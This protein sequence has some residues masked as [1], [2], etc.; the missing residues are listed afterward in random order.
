MSIRRP[1]QLFVYVSKD[2]PISRLTLLQLDAILGPNICEA[3]QRTSVSGVTSGSPASGQAN[4]ST[5]MATAL[6][7]GLPSTSRRRCLKE[8]GYGTATSTRLGGQF[9]KS[10]DED[11]KRAIEVVGKD[12]YAILYT[13]IAFRTAMVTPIALAREDGG[14][15]IEPTKENV[16]KTES[17]TDSNQSRSLLSARQENQLIP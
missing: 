5:F 6:T 14:P 1:G 8:A 16:A 13:G 4:R 15:Y 9:G 2:N 12:R 3:R 10:W 11:A 7:A 17:T